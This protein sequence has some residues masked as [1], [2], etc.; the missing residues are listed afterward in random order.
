LGQ[1]AEAG[2]AKTDALSDKTADLQALA[3]ALKAL[4]LED[5]ARLAAMLTNK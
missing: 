4:S 1:S 3:E 2:A 5:R